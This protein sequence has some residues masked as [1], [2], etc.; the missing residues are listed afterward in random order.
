MEQQVTNLVLHL[1]DPGVL[2]LIKGLELLEHDPSYRVHSVDELVV[3]ELHVLLQLE[4][5]ALDELLRDDLLVTTDGGREVG[6]G[7]LLLRDPGCQGPD[8]CGQPHA[9]S[10][11]HG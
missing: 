8:H 6:E 3:Q 4:L 5:I 2:G 9:G 1:T 10:G 7:L 11:G